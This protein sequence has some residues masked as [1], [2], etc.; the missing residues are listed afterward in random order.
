[1]KTKL[2]KL[3]ALLI[4]VI[5][6]VSAMP[7][8]A[9]A[10]TA[11]S[12]IE[13]TDITAPALGQMPNYSMM[14]WG[15]DEPQVASATVAWVELDDFPESITEMDEANWY[16]DY[17]QDFVFKADKYYVA[18]AE[19]LLNDGYSFERD[20]SQ[21]DVT[22]NGYYPDYMDVETDSAFFYYCFGEASSPIIDEIDIYDVAIP[23]VGASSDHSMFVNEFEKYFYSYSSLIW[24]E[25]DKAPTSFEEIDEAAWYYGGDLKFDASKYYVA[26]VELC[27]APGFT[28]VE[29]NAVE[30][31]INGDEPTF[32]D[33]HGEDN[34]WAYVYYC[35]GKPVSNVINNVEII[36]A[37]TPA[38]GIPAQYYYYFD[39]YYLFENYELIWAELD[40]APTSYTDVDEAVLYYNGEE[41]VFKADKYYVAIMYL[42]AYSYCEL[43]DT[44]FTATLNGKNY[45]YIDKLNNQ[46]VYLYFNLGKPSQPDIADN[47]VITGIKAPVAGEQ[48]SYDFDISNSEG[49][50]AETNYLI[51]VEMDSAPTSYEDVLYADNWYFDD[52]F[53]FNPDKYYVAVVECNAD[54]SHYLPA[55]GSDFNVTVNGNTPTFVYIPEDRTFADVCYNFGKPISS[56]VKL[57]D[58]T[59]DG[60]IN[61]NDA[62]MILRFAVGSLALS[63]EEIAAADVNKDGRVD[64]ADA[65]LILRYSVGQIENF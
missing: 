23:V 36:D 19:F 1:M 16:Y 17:N 35:Y 4:S 26:V 18:V 30:V 45:T 63:D 37:K 15:L 47:A 51:W 38:V 2:T 65:L 43:A 7:L 5:M 6:L 55:N 12:Y 61:S 44:G 31:M 25:L 49:L 40:K 56:S 24:V 59:G 54:D 3:L 20:L 10:E 60:T 62:L 22:I 11:V 52:N 21:F 27:I 29:E 57:G 50:S 13:I 8:S 28:F 14:Y 46:E 32:F 39:N 41:L 64:S 9:S 33:L 58:P 53:T 42:W 34:E 48:V